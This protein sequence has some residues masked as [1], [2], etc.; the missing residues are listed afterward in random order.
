M[1]REYSVVTLGTRQEMHAHLAGTSGSDGVVIAPFE[2]KDDL[3]A[4]AAADLVRRAGDIPVVLL[5]SRA[6]VAKQALAREL[7]VRACV[8]TFLESDRI[9]ERIEALF[10]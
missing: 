10:S 7:G 2:I 9:V 4:W 8:P 1:A 6:S 5:V 3:G